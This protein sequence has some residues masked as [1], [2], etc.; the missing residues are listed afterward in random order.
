M[1]KITKVLIL[2]RGEIACRLIQACQE[3]GLKTVAL[4]SDPD[5]NSRHVELADEAIHLKGSSPQETY[6]N[7]DKILQS[8]QSLKCDAVHPGYGFLSERAHAAEAFLKA[9]IEWVG[10][11]PESIRLLGDKLEAKKLLDKYK[12]PTAPWSEVNISD[13]ASLEKAAEKVGFPLLLK[14]ASGGGGKGMRLVREKKTLL[15]SAES[16]AREAKSSFGDATLLME[17]YIEEPR[18][19]EIQILGDLHGNLIHFGERECSLQRRHQKVIEEAPAPNLS[20]ATKDKIAA[21]AVALAK[22]VG[23]ASAGTVEYLVDKNENFY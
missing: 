1:A 15:E 2:N 21:S 20:Q 3:L 13:K 23:Y 17:K 14:A 8:A 9:G 7:L 18:H 19:V 4:Y 6:L 11:R 5:K 16:A 10:P 22:G 12:V